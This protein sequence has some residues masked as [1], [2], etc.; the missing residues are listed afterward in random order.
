MD[1][2]R[3]I[4]KE[5]F[6]S[7]LLYL[8]FFIWWYVTGYGLSDGTAEEFTYVLGLPMWFFLSCVVGY[9]LFC[10]ATVLLVKV[11]FRNFPLDNDENRGIDK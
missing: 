2:N 6:L 3:Q 11:V 10:V 9:I 5:A 4:R 8:L 1:I 7:M